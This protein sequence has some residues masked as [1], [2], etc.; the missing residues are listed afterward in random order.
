MGC[1]SSKEETKKA[2]EPKQYSW[3]KKV[4][5]NTEDFKVTKQKDATIVRKPGSLNG[6]Q[7]VVEDCENCDIF[8]FDHT[9]TVSIDGCKNCRFFIGPVN[10]S[11]FLR[12]STACR[13]VVACQ[14]LRTRDL[15]D[16]DM[17]LFCFTKPSLET[18]KDLR[19]SCFQYNFTELLGLFGS[20]KLSPFNN[21]WSS[22]FDFNNSSESYRLISNNDIPKPFLN[23]PPEGSFG[24]YTEGSLLKDVPSIVPLTYGINRTRPHPHSAFALFKATSTE[25]AL[26]FCH[27]IQ[28][29]VVYQTKEV[30]LEKRNAIEIFGA[31][32]RA[33]SNE[34]VGQ[35]VIGIEINTAESDPETSGLAEALENIKDKLNGEPFVYFLPSDG[36][37]SSVIKQ[38]FY[39][40][41]PGLTM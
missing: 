41:E 22:V 23:L 29:G 24:T 13:V 20:A 18:T 32:H 40:A 8:V 3:D 19:I 25:A 30:K 9:D 37:T 27:S 33:A 35:S 7:F 16:T 14:Q 2:E 15:T 1:A 38:F 11:F 31:E 5:T 17:M 28:K 6:K 4:K 26:W 34:F 21:D 36:Q 12:E 10:G 39:V